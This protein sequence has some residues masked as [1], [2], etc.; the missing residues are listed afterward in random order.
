MYIIPLAWLRPK[1]TPLCH[2]ILVPLSFPF[3][4]P[5]IASSRS[6]HPLRI[7]SLHFSPPRA[8]AFPSGS[9]NLSLISDQ[10]RIHSERGPTTTFITVGLVSRLENS[11]LVRY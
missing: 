11:R 5:A 1:G 4:S 6:L 9:T 3:R 2:T 7:S 8:F 10:P